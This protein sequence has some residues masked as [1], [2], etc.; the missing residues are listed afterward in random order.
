MAVPLDVRD[1]HAV[2]RAVAGTVERLGG[3][4]L[5]VNAAGLV[6]G[7]PILELSEDW[8]A[9]LDT[10]LT[11]A[12]RCSRHAATAMIASGRGGEIINIGSLYSLFGPRR[13]ADYATAKTGVLGLTRALAVE[14]A[15]HSIQVNAILP[16]WIKSDLTRRTFES[17]AGEQIRRRT[18]AGRWGEPGTSPPRRCSS[19]P[20]RPTS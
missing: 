18:R 10:H 11:G 4:D 1:A 19:P 6:R 15:E 12:F 5:L 7:G 14:L 17:E 8:H 3:L 16:G 20:R 13:F 2:Q 9:V